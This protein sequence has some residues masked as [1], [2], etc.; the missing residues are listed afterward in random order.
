M[1]DTFLVQSRF[2]RSIVD[3]NL[4]FM[5]EG[6]DVMMVII[7]VDD[8]IVFASPMSSMNAL[9]AMLEREYEISDLGSC[10]FVLE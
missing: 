8:L 7:Y 3:H 9:K 6:N 4:Y 2:A 10:T 1:I 5:Q